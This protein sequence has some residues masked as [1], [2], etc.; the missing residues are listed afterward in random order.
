LIEIKE[1]LL[2]QNIYPPYRGM[3]FRMGYLEKDYFEYILL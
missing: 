2:L 3:R 1:K